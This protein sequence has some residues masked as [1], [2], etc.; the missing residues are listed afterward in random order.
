[1]ELEKEIHQNIGFA[2]EYQKLSVNILYS[3]SWLD[4]FISR[5]LKPFGLTIQQF[6]VLRI[7]RGQLPEPATIN[8]LIE[9][10]IDKSS[11]ASRLVDRL[12]HK[13]LVERCS[14]TVDKRSVHVKITHKGLDLLSTIDQHTASFEE[15]IHHLPEKEARELNRLLD[16]MRGNGKEMINKN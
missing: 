10:M 4:S 15:A 13:E 3:A 6:N 11:N 9:R 16:K 7:L 14:N 1:M 8:T 5:K 12:Q 2:S